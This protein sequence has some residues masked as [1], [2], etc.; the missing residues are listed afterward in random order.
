MA[1]GC[2]G[3]EEPS[4]SPTAGGRSI[5]PPSC[6]AGSAGVTAT[7]PSANKLVSIGEPLP[8]VTQLPDK[9]FPWQQEMAVDLKCVSGTDA[10]AEVV[11]KTNTEGGKG[12]VLRLIEAVRDRSRRAARRQ[13]LADRAPRKLLLPASAVRQDLDPGAGRRG[14]D[15]AGRPATR[16]GA[17]VTAAASP[18]NHVAG[19]SPDA[20]E[21]LKGRG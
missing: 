12:E 18:S 6:G 5:P 20:D 1:S 19:A 8:D 4:P 21:R 7:R 11:F 17:G 13:G 10:G 3:R 2:S 14:L 9:G 16:V 15:V